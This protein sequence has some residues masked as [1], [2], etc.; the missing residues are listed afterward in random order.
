MTAMP[1]LT[2]RRWG[3]SK[4]KCSSLSPIPL[5]VTPWTVA[6]RLLCP[7]KSPGKNIGVRSHSL[8]QGG[9]PTQGLN[10]GLSHCRQILYRLGHQGGALG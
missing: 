2:T 8:L 5:L 6:A 4:G 10:P 7:R 3:P 9:F 1:A